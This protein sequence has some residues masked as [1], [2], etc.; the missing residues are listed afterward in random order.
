LYYAE[1]TKEGQRKVLPYYFKN[2]DKV[3][4]EKEAEFIMFG[5]A[6][7]K[8]DEEIEQILSEARKNGTI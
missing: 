4:Q 3:K 7:G 8:S 2:S 5:K 1:R 6:L